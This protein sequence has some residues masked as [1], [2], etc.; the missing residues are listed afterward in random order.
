MENRRKSFLEKVTNQIRSNEAKKYVSDEL[1]H[2]VK[3]A[4]KVW[5]NKGFSD[6]EAEQNAIEQMGSPVI[7]GMKLNK[8]H[9]PR[10]D[11]M[12]IML[13]GVI[14]LLGFLPLFTPGYWNNTNFL[15]RKAVF[16]VLGM[17]VT[18][19]LM[20]VDYRKFMKMGWLFYGL[21]TGL[22]LSLCFFSNATINGISVII[23]GPLTLES[24]FALPFFLA[25][26]AS[27]FNQNTFKVWHFVL[28]FLLSLLVF[29]QIPSLSSTY[30]Y[31]AMVM[32]M[33]WWSKFCT[34]QKAVV[35]G[36]TVSSLILTGILTWHYQSY[37]IKE[38]IIGFLQPEKVAEGSGYQVLHIHE[39]MTKA[40][41]F[42]GSKR[43]QEFIPEAHT[44]LVFVN[45][46]YHFGWIAAIIIALIL[47][48]VIARM[49]MVT[50]QVRDSFGKLLIIGGI[51]LYLSQV[52]SNIGMALG[53]FPLT[54]M[55][56]PFISYGL[57]PILL[58]S[59]LLGIVLSVYRRKNF[60]YCYK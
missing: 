30:L 55:S 6:E 43:I 21:G 36:I 14:L 20:V 46:T 8:I 34:R 48:L 50:Q 58:N 41:W 2:H 7:L 39:L 31:F 60:I 42:G 12:L 5:L 1:T 16:I 27:F 35:S 57:M 33:L 38:R 23:I 28:L 47:S 51:S 22:L 11:W 10:I 4:K 26:W 19:G 52:G 25:A 15:T 49:I 53:F 56:L 37:Y 29:I 44:N 24:L 45:I 32:C 17:T 59:I 40:K 18:L 3:E 13:M 9:R 54:S